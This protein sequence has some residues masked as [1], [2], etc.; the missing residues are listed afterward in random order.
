MGIACFGVCGD[1]DGNGDD[2]VFFDV[3][4]IDPTIVRDAAGFIGTESFAVFLDM[5]RDGTFDVIAGIPVTPTAA[6]PNAGI[7][8][9]GVFAFNAAAVNLPLSF[10]FGELL[11]LNVQIACTPSITCPH[12]EFTV[13]SWSRVP[14]FA[15]WPYGWRANVA[16]FG[17]SFEDGG[18]GEDW[19]GSLTKPRTVDF[20]CPPYLR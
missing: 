20:L 11:N 2:G 15:A 16:V 8:C 9:L 10:R 12:L 6:C 18:I 13:Q 19:I 4:S 3:A 1:A 14:H 7:D 17:G 5:D